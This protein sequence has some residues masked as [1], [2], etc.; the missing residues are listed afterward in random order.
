MVEVLKVAKKKTTTTT[1]KKERK[2]KTK[3]ETDG[4]PNASC[5]NWYFQRHL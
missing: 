1:T 2:K 5:T 3:N 4:K